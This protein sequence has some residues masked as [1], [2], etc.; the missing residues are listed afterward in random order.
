MTETASKRQYKKMAGQEDPSRTYG[1]PLWFDT[2]EVLREAFDH[3]SWLDDYRYE[4]F[5]TARKFEHAN[6]AYGPVCQLHASLGYLEKLGLA[7]IESDSTDRQ[8]E[9]LTQLP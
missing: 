2:P 1:F 9:Q 6:P 7:N 3:Y 5:E 4:L 8:I